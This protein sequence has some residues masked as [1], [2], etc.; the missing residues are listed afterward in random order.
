M[1]P[2]FSCFISYRHSPTEVA[3]QF[4]QDLQ[5]AFRN[6]FSLFEPNDPL[7]YPVFTDMDYLDPNLSGTPLD[8]ALADAIY[9]SA[10]MVM[11]FTPHYFH[12]QRTYCAQEYLA[13]RQLQEIRQALTLTGNK[14]IIPV[15]FRGASLIPKEIRTG[16]DHF[17]L[18]AL[19]LY[20]RSLP[21]TVFAETCQTIALYIYDQ[22]E[23]LHQIENFPITRDQFALPTIE[24]AN[25]WLQSNM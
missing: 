20:P 14:F 1:Q 18:S 4:V 7:P 17:D 8:R 21:K 22:I 12:R 16:Y 24:E 13:M 19:P 2:K 10:C 15:I 3:E 25:N 9:D 23:R 6:V 5:N 11:L